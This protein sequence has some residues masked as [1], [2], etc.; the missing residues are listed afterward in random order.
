LGS[1]GDAN[2]G[3]HGVAERRPGDQVERAAVTS[4]PNRAHA[5]PYPATVRTALARL[6]AAGALGLRDAVARAAAEARRAGAGDE[7]LRETLRMLVPYAGYPRA[8]AAF[9]A[10]GLAPAGTGAEADEAPPPERAR[11]GREA[12]DRVYGSTAERVL[13]GL[14]A[15]DPLLP[16]WT[17]EHAYGRVLA[18]SALPLLE[19]ELLAV[20]LLTALGALEEPLLGHLRG[21]RRLGASSADLAAAVDAVPPEVDEARRAAARA[22]LAR[23]DPS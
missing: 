9:G 19:R 2:N 13:A 16:A 5:A 14:A 18:R 23:V 15:L 4:G 8:L 22:L 21:A 17:L 11:R 12:F 1:S 20:S 3:R 6:A 10:A 7:A